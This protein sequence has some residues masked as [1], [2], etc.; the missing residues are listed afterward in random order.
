MKRFIQARVNG[1]SNYDSLEKILRKKGYKTLVEHVFRVA[2]GAHRVPDLL[3]WDENGGRA[4]IIDVTVVSDMKE[5]LD[6]A[7]RE[8]VAFYGQY[9]EIE[10]QTEQITGARPSFSAFAVNWRGCVSPWTA[11]D[12]KGLGLTDADL[13]LLSAITVEQG[14]IIH[15]LKYRSRGGYR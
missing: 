8:K 15:R 9:P 7:H 2:D 1:G 11:S 13:L 12:M 6:E 3:V 10:E 5:P 4:V 14:A